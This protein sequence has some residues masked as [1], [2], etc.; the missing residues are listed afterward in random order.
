MFTLCLLLLAA[1]WGYAAVPGLVAPKPGSITVVIDNNYPPYIFKDP[2]TGETRGLLNDRWALWSRHTGVE[3]KLKPMDWAEAQRQLLAGEADVIDTLFENEARRKLYE[4]SQPTDTIDVPVFFHR[5]LAGGIG[6]DALQG[7][8]V[9]VKD[10]DAC[11]DTLKARGV[12]SMKRYPGYSAVI[13]G[14]ARNEVQVFCVDKPPAIYLLSQLGLA[15]QY[16]HSVPLSSGQFHRAVRKG[17][18]ALLAWVEAGF[19]GLPAAEM[20]ALDDRWLGTA[21]IDDARVP[22]RDWLRWAAYGTGIVV[23]GGLMLVYWNLALRRR[24][25]ARTME[26]EAA[27]QQAERAV[28]Q[29]KATLE[30]IPDLMFEMDSDGRYLDVRTGRSDLLLVPAARLLGRTLD[31]LMPPEA[32]RVAKQALQEAAETGRSSGAQIRLELAG[33]ARWFELSVARKPAEAGQLDRFVVLSRDITE[34]KDAE[35]AVRQSEQTFRNFFSAGLMGMA[36]NQPNGSWGEV[37]QALCRMLGYPPEELSG[38]RW[39]DMTHPDD[40][41]A[42]LAMFERMARGEIESYTLDK[43]FIR[44]DG[45]II[46]VAVAVCCERDSQGA[47]LRSFAIVDDISDR[48]RARQALSDS[49]EELERRVQ[50][51]SQ[52]LMLARDQAQQASRA[53]SEFLSRMSHELRTP[54]NAILGFSQLM[55]LD[56]GLDQRSQGYVTEILRAGRHLLELI[57]EVLDLAQVEAGSIRLSLEPLALD[58]LVGDVLTLMGPLLQSQ[59]V[60]VQVLDLRTFQVQADRTRLK[61]VMLNL[62]TNAVKYNRPGGQVLIRAERR[63]DGRLRIIVRDTGT[64]IAPERMSQLFEPFNRLGAEQRAIEG[65]GIGLS[66]SRQLVELMHG[67]IGASSKPGEGSVFWLD[68][69]IPDAPQGVVDTLVLPGPLDADQA[70]TSAHPCRGDLLYVEDNPSNVDLVT[71]IVARHPAI[72][73]RVATSGE[74]GLAMAQEQRPDLVLLDIHLPGMSG[75]QVLEQLRADLFTRD[76]AVVALTASALTEDAEQARVAG[77]DDFIAKPIN[78]LSFEAMLQHR[79]P[80]AEQAD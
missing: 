7:F 65:T 34:R 72:T 17:Q 68:L 32:A 37:N 53:K 69:P 41:P 74:E 18:G 66:I 54:M 4:F 49:R 63:P 55:E 78:L 45:Q 28:A 73:L 21:I 64:G 10:G 30:A 5:S 36:F 46:D 48:L 38:M 44:K 58:V 61:Q 62:L 13:E 60:S 12:T 71:S 75:Y 11:V 14:A 20:K 56:A 33:G 39:A 51:R 57:N 16:R 31:E 2:A 6:I 47:I 52:E 67:D 76:I 77:F 70:G 25:L 15:D 26:L 3:V 79:L 8:T 1:S 42:N 40:L 23:L 19:A 27:R 80:P 43:R 9:G 29:L 50:E 35:L 22:W 24:V 59:A